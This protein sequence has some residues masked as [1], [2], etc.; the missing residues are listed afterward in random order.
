MQVIEDFESRPQKAVTFVSK[1]ERKG[2]NGTSKNC[3]TSYLDTAEEDDQ[4]EARKRKVG[5]KEKKEK[6]NNK[7]GEK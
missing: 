4:E 6:N 1:E 2:R 5:K 7:D 3:R